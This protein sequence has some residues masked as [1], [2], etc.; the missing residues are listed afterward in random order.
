MYTYNC[1]I[2]KTAGPVEL[3]A[4]GVS[5]ALFN[6]VSRIA[7]FPLVSVTT[8]FVAEEDTIGTPIELSEFENASSENKLLIPQEGG[9]I[10]YINSL[11]IFIFVCFDLWQTLLCNWCFFNYI[12]CFIGQY[13]LFSLNSITCFQLIISMFSLNNIT[14]S[15]LVFSLNNIT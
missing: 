6:Q 8:S 4:V 2:A 11:Y 5:I 1:C 12:P 9:Y 15:V 14:W 7:I 10:I 13:Y 3:G